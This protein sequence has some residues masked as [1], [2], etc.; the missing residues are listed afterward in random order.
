MIKKYFNIGTRCLL[1]LISFIS[2]GGG[3]LVTSALN[4]S[5][6]YKTEILIIY[7]CFYAVSLADHYKQLIDKGCGNG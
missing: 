3:L 4:D 1:G 2:V 5:N 6:F 7:G